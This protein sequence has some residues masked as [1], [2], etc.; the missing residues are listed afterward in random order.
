MAL[1]A[2]IVKQMLSGQAIKH[3]VMM[4]NLNFV[5]SSKS[6]WLSNTLSGF[7]CL[8]SCVKMPWCYA[9]WCSNQSVFI[10][11]W[12]EKKVGRKVT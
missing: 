4:P 12:L 7:S 5:R 1:A 10:I 2:A 3:D 8:V 9:R 6:S 11:C